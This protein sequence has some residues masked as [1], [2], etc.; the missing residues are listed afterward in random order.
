M[1]LLHKFAVK[2]LT[3][4]SLYVDSLLTHMQGPDMFKVLVALLVIAVEIRMVAQ[5]LTILLGKVFLIVAGTDI[6]YAQFLL[7]LL[8]PSGTKIW[9]LISLQ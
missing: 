1:W 3:F 7:P 4:K 6:Q 2:H 8:C 9:V 5:V